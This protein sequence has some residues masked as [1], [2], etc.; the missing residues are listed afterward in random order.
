MSEAIVQLSTT[1]IM[2]EGQVE[3]MELITSVEDE[4]PKL[5]GRHRL[6]KNL[7]KMTSIE[8]LAVEAFDADYPRMVW[9]NLLQRDI[10]YFVVSVHF[11]LVISV[12]VTDYLLVVVVVVHDLAKKEQLLMAS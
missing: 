9:K 7:Q 8:M 4:Q 6:L 12:V 10:L 11:L 3:I 5:K 2:E 1:P